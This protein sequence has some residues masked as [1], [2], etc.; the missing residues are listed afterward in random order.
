L[1]ESYLPLDVHEAK[2]HL[3]R[4]MTGWVED[5]QPQIDPLFTAL[6]WGTLALGVGLVVLLAELAGVV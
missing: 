1:I 4:Y 2:E 3:A 6:R 5:N